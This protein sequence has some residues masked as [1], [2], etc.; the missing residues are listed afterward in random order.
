MKYL[1][2]FVLFAIQTF[3]AQN[4]LKFVEQLESKLDSVIQTNMESQHI[5]GLAFIIIKDGKTLLKKGYGYT[6][7]GEEIRRV[8]P[9]STI[10][11]IGSITKTFTATALL[12]L[13][14]GNK[15]DLRKDVN[16]YLTSVQV[17]NTFK[18]PVTSSNLLNHSAGFDELRGR[19]VYNRNQSIPLGE[20]LKDKLIR[21]REPGIV[22][23]YSSYGMALAGL[24]VEDISQMSLESYMKK[25]IW[26]PLKM[27]MTS[28]FLND[29]VEEHASWGYEYRNGINIPQPWEYYHTYPASE[30][31]STV[32]DMGKYMQMHLNNG[33]LDEERILSDK[34]AIE[35]KEQQ[36]SIDPDLESFGYGFYEEYAQGHRTVS[37]GGDMLGYA[38]YMALVP[39]MNLGVYVVH[40]HEGARL[41]YQVLNSIL[42]HYNQ[43]SEPE[44]KRKKLKQDLTK[45]AGSYMWSTYCHT[46]ENSW[47]PDP[48]MI[49]VNNDNTLNILGQ[50][51]I[52]IDAL[53]F[54]NE[55]GSR[56]IG[57]IEDSNGKIKYMSTGA[58]NMFERI[59]AN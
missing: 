36:L 34:L 59:D 55:E 48:E 40:H 3:Y 50:K 18:Q 8:N 52:Q 25:N 44:K 45:F 47:K 29:Q 14:D 37:H 9:D 2:I 49:T 30:I 56:K 58:S 33:I 7:L 31:N 22:S 15:I 13:V 57:F 51:Y 1:N 5:P 32:A 4:N 12:Q 6:S 43:N 16:N 21:L 53:L 28:M 17:P 11:R 23:S 38:G 24:L 42:A 41:R 10:F 27:N 35:M 20:F 54:Q 39:E 19:V 26:E 46:C